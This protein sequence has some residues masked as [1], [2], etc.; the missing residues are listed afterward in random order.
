MP[1][2]RQAILILGMHRSGTSALTRALSLCGPALPEHLIPATPKNERGY[3]ESQAIYELHEGLL[4]DAG[5]SWRDPSPFPASWF[6][7]ESAA[8]W[9][10]RL[11]DAVRA[12]YG[13]SPFF[14]LKDPRLCRLVPIWLRVLKAL[15]TRP[16][17]ALPIRDPLEV[18]AS[19][20]RSE[21]V[22]ERLGAMLWL[23]YL[24]AAEQDTRGQR[25]SFVLYADLLTDWRRVLA[26]VSADL[27]F[28]LPRL[29]RTAEAEVDEF[30]SPDL[31]HEVSDPNALAA[32]SDGHPWVRDAYQWARAAATGIEPD[33]APLD[34]IRRDLHLAESAFG[35]ILASTELAC[36][37]RDAEIARLE[38]LANEFEVQVAE[39]RR[40]A[41]Q[42]RREVAATRETARVLLR[43]AIE[44]GRGDRAAPPALRAAL[45]A[46]ATANAMEVPAIASTAL[47]LTEQRLEIERLTRERES[48][49]E[50]IEKVA[51]RLDESDGRV[52]ERDHQIERLQRGAESTRFELLRLLTARTREEE[53]LREV[54]AARQAAAAE[55]Q[56]LAAECRRWMER[57]DELAKRIQSS[58]DAMPP[59][60]WSR[61]PA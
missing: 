10:R 3:F 28:P 53:Q 38:V 61:G 2:K 9:E 58:E 54:T 14:V 34:A 13:E 12:E 19:L 11:I 7:T 24:L 57:C 41:V 43:W 56:R 30:L 22:V 20:H 33:P 35:P 1:V 26:K 48:L 59:A 4:R 17:F 29:S 55:A 5:T 60:T 6:A 31:R 39:S 44:R 21:D 50:Q 27:D 52:R 23:E 25:R 37:T 18:A 8:R 42:Q 36:R 51:L 49:A 15:D 45:D 47:A 32:R 46:F 40:V 16:L